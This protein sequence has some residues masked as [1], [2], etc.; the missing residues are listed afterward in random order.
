MTRQVVHHDSPEDLATTVA[1]LLLARLAELQRRGEVPQVG[2]T[3]GG[4]A[5]ALHREVARLSPGS[6]V[7]WRR[8][9]VW[10]GDERFVA[11]DS[12]DRNA[13]QARDALLS[14]VDVDPALVHEVPSSS[15]VATA[16]ESAR[17]YAGALAEH[18][19]Q[20]LDVLM[21]GIGPDG[22]LASL[23]PG[24]PAARTTDADT[25]AVHDSPKPPPDRVSLTFPALNRARSVWFLASGDGK[26]DAAA[27]ALA[28]TADGP[29][30]RAEPG[31]P[32]PDAVL[33]GPAAGVHGTDETVWHVD[34]TTA[35]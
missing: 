35:R 15:A 17:A 34:P 23:F 11:D 18:G 1:G 32:L 3:G 20:A 16:E 5:D 10:W 24:H 33:E 2:L 25:V 22:H 13:G 14:A 30:T 28:L 9:G 6:G 27:R 29:L 4:I 8:V 7:D 26:A 12:P 21:L 19:V 31:R